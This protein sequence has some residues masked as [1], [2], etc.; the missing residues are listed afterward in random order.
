[1]FVVF[2]LIQQLHEML[3]QTLILKE[4]RSLQDRLQKIYEETIELT[5]KRPEEILKIVIK[6]HRSK[7]NVLLIESSERDRY[8]RNKK[9]K[10]NVSNKKSDYSATNLKGLNLQEKIFVGN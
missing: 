9:G 6:A 1:M 5:T 10:K 7:V 3:Q 4:T 8:N 2:P